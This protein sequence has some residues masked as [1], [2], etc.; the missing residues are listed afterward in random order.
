MPPRR[1]NSP[2]RRPRDR[3]VAEV[4]Q[5][6]QERVLMDRERRTG[7]RAASPAGRPGGSCAGGG[8]GRSPPGRGRDRSA[9]RPG[10]RHGPPSRRRSARSARTPARS[11]ARARRQCRDPRTR[12]P[13]PPRRDRRSRRR[14]RSRPGARHRPRPRVRTRGRSS[15]RADGHETDVRPAPAPIVCASAEAHAEPRPTCPSRRAAAAGPTGPGC[16]GRRHAVP[17]GSP[18]RN[19]PARRRAPGCRGRRA[20]GLRRSPGIR[21]LRIDLGDVEVDLLPRLRRRVTGGEVGGDPFG[22]PSIASTPTAERR[23]RHRQSSDPDG[24]IRRQPVLVRRI[25][26]GPGGP[27]TSPGQPA[28]SRPPVGARTC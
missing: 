20:T 1:A 14:G 3:D 2:R 26:S 6:V 23:V 9:R 16:A 10:Q 4:E 5:V 13:A 19:R 15:L 7:A 11:V 12:P 8:P 24:R 28:A 27:S 25:P 18:L 22:D 21:D 17:A